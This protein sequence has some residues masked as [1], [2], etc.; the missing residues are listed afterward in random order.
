MGP[1]R[2]HVHAVPLHALLFCHTHK[3]YFRASELFSSIKHVC[4]EITFLWEN[5]NIFGDIFHWFFFPPSS[6]NQNGKYHFPSAFWNVTLSV[7][8]C[9]FKTAQFILERFR[10]SS[11]LYHLTSLCFHYKCQC[12][13][14]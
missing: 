11:A 3:E 2:L 1:H 4:V 14:C 10:T 6:G 8:K 9:Q 7:L 5:I 13:L 12:F